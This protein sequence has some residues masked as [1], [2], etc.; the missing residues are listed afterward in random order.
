V[1]V[2]L[3]NLTIAQFQLASVFGLDR[4]QAIRGL[5]TL[6]DVA[7]DGGNAKPFLRIYG[8]QTD[9]D[10]K[11]G[12]VFPLSVESEIDSHRTPDRMGCIARAVRRMFRTDLFRHQC[13]DGLAQQ[14]VAA[15]AGQ[16]FGRSVKSQNAAFAVNFDDRVRRGFEQ[17]AQTLVGTMPALVGDDGYR[18]L[19]PGGGP[20]FYLDCHAIVPDEPDVDDMT[21]TYQRLHFGRQREAV[22]L[23]FDRSENLLRAAAPEPYPASFIERDYGEERSIEQGAKKF[24]GMVRGH[25]RL[26]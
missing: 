17:F 7:D 11:G 25:A 10:R 3:L 9:F 24:G 12:A 2:G 20:G 14:L 4:L 15:V 18:S 21:G 22:S 13:F 6:G 5:P 1:A 23:R 8:T 16:S 26:L 19:L